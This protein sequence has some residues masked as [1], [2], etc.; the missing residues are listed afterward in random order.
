M[1]WIHNSI[2]YVK[3]KS[4]HT[5]SYEDHPKRSNRPSS[6]KVNAK[7]FVQLHL[8]QRCKNNSSNYF[9]RLLNQRL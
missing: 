5:A 4:L 7:P 3:V 8:L 1:V 2:N 9:N 6:F